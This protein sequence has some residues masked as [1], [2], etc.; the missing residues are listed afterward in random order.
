M[1][2]TLSP[3]FW[4]APR[5]FV[6]RNLQLMKLS[7]SCATCYIANP[8]NKPP[9]SLWKAKVPLLLPITHHNPC[10]W[11]TLADQVLLQLWELF[12]TPWGDVIFPP[13]DRHS[14]PKDL[15]YHDLEIPT[16]NSLG[17][18]K[19]NQSCT[20]VCLITLFILVQAWNTRT[21]NYQR[22]NL[23]Q[24]EGMESHQRLGN[25]RLVL[26]GMCNAIC[27]RLSEKTDGI[28][29][30]PHSLQMAK[31]V[32]SLASWSGHASKMTINI[33]LETQCGGRMS[34]HTGF[35]WWQVSTLVALKWWSR[36]VP[37][38]L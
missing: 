10:D 25:L 15:I 30:S 9:F 21:P 38:E 22:L 37:S 35:G 32:V 14:G 4:R 16:W 19:T 1:A 5:S 18:G 34:Q 13:S 12:F 20:V 2:S 36:N 24:I 11:Y 29:Y 33:R 17:L 8:E 3:W 23:L 7:T 6:W 28:M 26:G 27:M 31:A